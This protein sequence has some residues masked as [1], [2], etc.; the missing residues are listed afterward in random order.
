MIVLRKSTGSA[1]PVG[2]P[3]VVQHLQQNVE[4]VAVGPEHVP[5]KSPAQVASLISIFLAWLV[6]GFGIV[7]FETP[8]DI[9]ALTVDGSMP[10]GNCRTR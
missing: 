7:T 5:T 2:Q 8:F 10:G 1:L 6:A 9:V 3:A 4:N